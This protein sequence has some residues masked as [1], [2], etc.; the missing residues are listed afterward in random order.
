MSTRF[1]KNA[2]YIAGFAS[3]LVD[4]PLLSRT[5]VGQPVLMYRMPDGRAVAIGNRCPH[6]FAPLDMGTVIDGAVR[7]AYHGLRFGANGSCTH[8]PH[9]P[10]S[11]ALAVPTYPLAERGGLLWLWPGD[12]AK[13]AATPAPEFEALD[14]SRFH[15]RH[16]YMHGRAGY[17]L[18]SDNILD[19]SHIEFLHPTVLGTEAVSLAKVTV[20]EGQNS[21]TTR[22]AMT[23]EILPDGLQY[24]YRTGRRKVNRT[25]TVSWRA[26][27]T[28]HLDVRVESAE[29][30]WDWRSGSQTLHL[31]SPETGHS[32]HYFYV[33]S[34]GRDVAD[35]E[36]ANRFFAGLER[37][38]VSE[39]KP[40][41]EAQQAMIDL[42]GA[43]GLDPALLGIDRGAVLARRRLARMIA[44]E[45]R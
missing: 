3:E 23:D 26:P 34:I 9:G 35:E 20:S 2:W 8:N 1:V 17:E 43:A 44:E 40:M 33:A 28:L 4:R 27:S 45:Q 22:R 25:L 32:T 10:V 37:A 38:F 29:P 15:V 14:E 42:S 19:L 36:R 30:D 31:F 24:V 5:I 18:M 7:C 13:A 11:R 41:I 21:V 16:G 39:D 6:R 12:P